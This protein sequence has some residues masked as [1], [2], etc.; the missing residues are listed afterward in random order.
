[1]IVTAFL[2]SLVMGLL[3]A[4]EYKWLEDLNSP[5]AL[6]WV[7]DRNVSAAAG[8]EADPRFEQFFEEAHALATDADRVPAVSLHGQDVYNVWKDDDHPR[9]VATVHPPPPP[10][11]R[12]S[13]MDKIRCSKTQTT[14]GGVSVDSITCDVRVQK[15]SMDICVL[16]VE[17]RL[18]RDG[19]SIERYCP[20]YVMPSVRGESVCHCNRYETVFFLWFRWFTTCK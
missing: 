19:A 11:P 4:D 17:P 2:V 9:H 13:H 15:P 7:A 16:S 14:E 20:V 8:F 10:A 12:A 1:M 18:Y 5:R 3:A 6:Q